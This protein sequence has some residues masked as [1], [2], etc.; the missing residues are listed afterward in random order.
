VAYTF[1]FDVTHSIL[2][3]RLNGDVDDA[4]LNDFFRTGAWYALHT[5]PGAGV[6]D[7]SEVTSFE[8][9]AEAVHQ[10]AQSRPVLPDPNLL[11]IVIAPSPETYGMMRMFE[12]HGE[13]KRPNLYVVH[14]EGEAWA[15]LGVLD[16]HFE[17]IEV[18]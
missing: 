7:L 15:I 4:A 16:P 6:V 5:R 3:C 14:T 1:D 11:R 17:P 12:I 8:A 10:V 13:E 9:T 2:R 18:E